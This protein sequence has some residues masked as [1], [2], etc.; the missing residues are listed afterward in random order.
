MTYRRRPAP[1][2]P[3]NRFTRP[4]L[5]DDRPAPHERTT[6]DAAPLRITA[7]Q[8][9]ALVI[10]I[11]NAVGTPQEDP[12]VALLRALAPRHELF[13]ARLTAYVMATTTDVEYRTVTPEMTAAHHARAVR[14]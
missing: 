7:D 8:I 3:F 10:A 4:G 6:P 1:P 13:A 11:G 2:M 9:A 5:P 14:R 12:L